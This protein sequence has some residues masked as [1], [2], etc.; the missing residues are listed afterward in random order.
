MLLLLMEDVSRDSVVGIETRYWLDG[1]GIESQRGRN[2]PRLPRPDLRAHSISN[3][4]G[5]VHS[6]G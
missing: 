1:P 6:R 3:T 2:V 4:M 5:P